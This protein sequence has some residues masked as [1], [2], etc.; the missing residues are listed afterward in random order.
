M[1]ESALSK[2]NI[3]AMFVA[4][5]NQEVDCGHIT[6]SETTVAFV[7]RNYGRTNVDAHQD[8]YAIRFRTSIDKANCNQYRF[9]FYSYNRQHKYYPYIEGR[10]KNII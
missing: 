7:K 6:E 8:A 5:D 2:L 1:T 9:H 10:N 3:F 4:E